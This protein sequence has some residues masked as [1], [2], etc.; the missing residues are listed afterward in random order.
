MD[1]DNQL[2]RALELHQQEAE[3]RRQQLAHRGGRSIQEIFERINSVPVN[4]TRRTA[5]S[6]DKKSGN[7]P[8]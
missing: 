6:N 4:N 2:E 1:R 8:S 5:K 7:K 3:R